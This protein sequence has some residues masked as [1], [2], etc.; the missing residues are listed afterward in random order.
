M[1]AKLIHANKQ[2]GNLGKS[3]CL[4]T[5]VCVR[6]KEGESWNPQLIQLIWT[7]GDEA[8]SKARG[9]AASQ[10]QFRRAAAG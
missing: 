5:T 9:T 1:C 3:V 7:E 6:Q 4:D 10:S 8:D 2:G